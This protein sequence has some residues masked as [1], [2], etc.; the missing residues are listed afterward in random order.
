MKIQIL[1][2]SQINQSR[3]RKNFKI[4]W[5]IHFSQILSR[6][7]LNNLHLRK[8][9]ITSFIQESNILNMNRTNHLLIHHLFKK[10]QMYHLHNHLKKPS[11]VSLYFNKMRNLKWKILEHRKF[12]SFK[13][14]TKALIIFHQA[15]LIR[16]NS[17]LVQKVKL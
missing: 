16:V 10:P 15:S 17:T 8:R 14:Q 4:S 11:K 12:L 1:L 5:K 3:M 9:V 7:T 6:R 13:R 2:V